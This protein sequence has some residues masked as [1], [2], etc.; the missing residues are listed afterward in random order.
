ML[1]FQCCCAAPGKD[2]LGPADKIGSI[3]EMLGGSSSVKPLEPLEL[4]GADY[5]IPIVVEVECTPQSKLGVA[6]DMTSDDRCFV[7]RLKSEGLVPDWNAKCP[8]NEDVQRFYRL[9]E[10]GDQREGAKNM[11]LGIQRCIAEGA[12][13]RM[14]F[15]RP[16]RF[17]VVISKFVF[18]AL[19]LESYV[20]H[21]DYLSGLVLSKSN[22]ALNQHNDKASD[23]ELI[24]GSSR[25]LGVKPKG[26]KGDF[27]R[28]SGE[29]M[30][31]RMRELPE[32]EIEVINWCEY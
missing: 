10:V 28:P 13:L 7:K 12:T 32:M 6:M 17:S 23:I 1:S 22:C 15:T 11:A 30:V 26:D 9:V 5:R 19:G 14:T 2:E 21:E 27:E 31:K 25:I 3:V 8:D 18:P 4:T 24:N 20:S 16:Y 29:Q